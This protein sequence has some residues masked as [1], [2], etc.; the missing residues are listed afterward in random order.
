M[1]NGSRNPA[2]DFLRFAGVL[3][4]MF[5]HT[6]IQGLSLPEKIAYYIGGGGWVGVD[7]FFVLSGYLV[8]G[9]IFKEVDAEGTFN[10]TRFLIRRGFKIY[11]AYYLFLAFAL[12]VTYLGH[13]NS[14]E[15]NLRILYEALFICN[16]AN[17]DPLHGWLWSI[18]VEEHFYFFLCVLLAMLI[19]FRLL[20][21]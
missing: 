16:Y 19:R 2:L 11:P 15:N 21:V 8:S 6:S 3:L 5:A 17:P 4:V 7:L 14:H 9:L 10:S 18:C 20:S 1:L 12:G 13:Y